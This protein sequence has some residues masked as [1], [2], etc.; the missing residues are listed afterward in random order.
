MNRTL[1]E[2]A[3]SMLNDAGLS[4]DYWEE[5]VNTTCYVVNNSL[6]LALVNNV[7]DIATSKDILIV[8]ISCINP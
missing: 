7:D 3:R 8:F 2:K 5:V 1:M 4:Q 6:T